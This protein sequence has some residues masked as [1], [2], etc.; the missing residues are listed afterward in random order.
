[1]E[2]RIHVLKSIPVNLS[3]NTDMHSAESKQDLF[4]TVPVEEGVVATVKAE[5]YAQSFS[6]HHQQQGLHYQ[7]MH[8]H[9]A[10]QD[11]ASGSHDRYMKDEQCST[12]DS[13]TFEDSYPEETMVRFT[14]TGN[15]SYR[16]LY[17][18]GIICNGI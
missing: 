11:S 8:Y 18:S 9:S 2:N 10:L 16:P 7:R 17:I 6:N 13:S 3:L 1:M 4:D 14:I 5:V 12:P 15:G